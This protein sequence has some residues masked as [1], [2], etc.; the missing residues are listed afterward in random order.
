MNGEFRASRNQVSIFDHCVTNINPRNLLVQAVAGSGKSTTLF[1]LVRILKERGKLG[2]AVLLAF[3]KDIATEL[4][5]KGLPAATFHSLGLAAIYQYCRRGKLIEPTIEQYKC[6]DIFDHMDIQEDHKRLYK[7]NVL[8]LVSLSKNANIDPTTDS[9]VDQIEDL[10]FRHDVDS[11]HHEYQDVI[12]AMYTSNVLMKSNNDI[13][14]IDF[15]DMLYMPVNRMMSFATYKWCFVDESQDTNLLQREFL[16][17]LR[18]QHYVFV[19]DRSQAIYG[20]RGAD[21]EAMDLI[22]DEFDCAEL[23]LSVCYRC[24]TVVLDMARPYCPSI[25]AREN[26]PVGVFK[27]LGQDYGLD[28][29]VASDVVLCRNIR[30]LITLALRMYAEGLKA[31]LLG[32]DI[33]KGIIKLVD[34]MK[35]HSTENLEDNLLA[36]YTKLSLKT[37]E[38]EQGVLESLLDKIECI[39]A[40]IASLEVNTI[41]NL[42]KK[43]DS[44][45]SQKGGVTLS[46]IHKSKG[47]QW[48]RVFLL[49]EN[50]LPSPYAKQGWQIQQ[51]NNL[52]YVS[53]TRAEKELYFIASTQSS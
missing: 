1:H 34:K 3:N 14:L 40:V 20:F 13:A 18:A 17:L 4:K 28:E 37:K 42:R 51:E 36:F 25:E 2:R 9:A 19:G 21:S 5:K 44:L 50:L 12:A 6:A 22:K 30:P 15:D 8:K 24:P 10:A 35:A 16:R 11:E 49:D 52:R 23:P 26:A 7:A 46:T 39:Q 48:P 33:G 43:I 27:D 38:S 41:E 45:F 47:G 32:R 29:F 31:H 53:Y